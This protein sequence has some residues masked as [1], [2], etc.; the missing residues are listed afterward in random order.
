MIIIAILGAT[1]FVV[2]LTLL[3]RYAK[4]PAWSHR[5]LLAFI[6]L[7]ATVGGAIL[8]TM[9]KVMQN[10]VFNRQADRLITELVRDSNVRSEVGQVLNT[11]ID[12]QAWNIKM[13]SAGIIV[14]LLSLGLVISSRIIKGK[15][16]GNE[17][18]MGTQHEREAAAAAAGARATAK[19]ADEKAD[20]IAA[21]P[22][23]AA[24]GEGELPETEKIR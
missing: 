22:A 1:A 18:E 4:V 13:D 23:A 9:L 12:A 7:I 19:A 20:S 11:I 24:L 14:V 2:A 21:T 3:L 15:I 8:L 17:F 10:D 6:A 16:L 5:D